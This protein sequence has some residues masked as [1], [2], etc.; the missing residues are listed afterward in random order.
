MFKNV[1]FIGIKCIFP[2]FHCRKKQYKSTKNLPFF[3]ISFSAHNEII[4]SQHKKIKHR[5]K[6]FV[7]KKNAKNWA[8]RETYTFDVPVNLTAQSYYISVLPLFFQ[9]LF[10][11]ALVCYV[12]WMSFLFG[13]K[14]KILFYTMRTHKIAEWLKKFKLVVPFYA[15]RH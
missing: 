2:A 9:R 11:S 5:E 3:L 15:C 8:E 10:S 12:K 14:K 6:M 1:M 4:P 7:T 13:K